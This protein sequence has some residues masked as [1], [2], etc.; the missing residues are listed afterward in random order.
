MIGNPLDI[1]RDARFYGAPTMDAQPPAVADTNAAGASARGMVTGSGEVAQHSQLAPYGG[2]GQAYQLPHVL[3]QD[4][5]YFL[6]LPPDSLYAD[7]LL[8]GGVRGFSTFSQFVPLPP[9]MGGF[10]IMAFRPPLAPLMGPQ[11]AAQSYATD[12]SWRDAPPVVDLCRRVPNVPS[13]GGGA[14]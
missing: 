13:A 12:A 8:V 6:D 4:A 3:G 5:P 7:R 11:M 9:N 10:E 1:P 2:A 14:P